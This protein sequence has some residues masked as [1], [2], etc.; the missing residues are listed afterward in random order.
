MKKRLKIIKGDITQQEV[1]AIV[2]A[3]D[4]T[5]LN[6]GGINGAIHQAAGPGLLEECKQLGGCTVGQAKLTQGYQLPAKYVIHTVGPTWRGGVRGEPK[7]LCS[8]YEETLNIALKNGIKTLAFP[9]ISCGIH[10]YPASQAATIAIKEAAD[11]LKQHEEI[12]SVS[13]VC[14]DDTLFEIY[15]RALDTIAVHHE[16]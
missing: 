1:D 9:T 12:E 7:L 5:L 3:A 2:N 8:C 6:G 13:F 4:T 16:P 14:Y 10:G 15:Q 11:F